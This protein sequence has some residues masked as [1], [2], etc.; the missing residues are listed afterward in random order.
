[1]G[2]LDPDRA[3]SLGVFVVL[4]PQLSRALVAAR[5]LADH[6]ISAR[7]Y[8]DRERQAPVCLS[9]LDRPGRVAVRVARI[10]REQRPR[11]QRRPRAAPPVEES[12]LAVVGIARYAPAASHL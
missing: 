6:W 4:R 1:M 5:Q 12:W 3:S 9:C 2:M 10:L 8:G 7:V 11:G